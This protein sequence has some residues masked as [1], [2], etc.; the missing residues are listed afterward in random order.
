MFVNMKRPC[1]H[2]SLTFS[3]SVGLFTLELL[4]KSDTRLP[5]TG[6][7]E[8]YIDFGSVELVDVTYQTL[9]KF[10][11]DVQSFSVST[12]FLQGQVVVILSRQLCSH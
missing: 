10:S 3:V 4:Q 8:N 12:L 9:T 2:H 1:G 6:R 11:E 7:T 5:P